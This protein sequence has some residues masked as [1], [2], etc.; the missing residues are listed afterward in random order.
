MPRI[1]ENKIRRHLLLASRKV[2]VLDNKTT[3]A[4]SGYGLKFTQ[5]KT[6]C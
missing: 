5:E 4:I 2:K 1:I 3:A 6:C